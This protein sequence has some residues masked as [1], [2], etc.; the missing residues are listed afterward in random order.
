MKVMIFK[1]ECSDTGAAYQELVESD[2]SDDSTLEF[3]ETPV[4]NV[5]VDEYGATLY[6]ESGMLYITIPWSELYLIGAS[7]R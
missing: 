5:D 7:I 1:G 3:V 4:V 2:K 6:T